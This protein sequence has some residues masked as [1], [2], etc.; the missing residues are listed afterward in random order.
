MR[1]LVLHMLSQP[2]KSDGSPASSVAVVP[3]SQGAPDTVIPAACALDVSWRD[4]VRQVARVPAFVGLGVHTRCAALAAADERARQG[5]IRRARS[6]FRSVLVVLLAKAL[7]EDKGVVSGDAL[8]VHVR[9]TSSPTNG[10]SAA[11]QTPGKTP[12]KPASP[13]YTRGGVASSLVAAGSATLASPGSVGSDA[14]GFGG[15]EATKTGGSAGARKAATVALA[16]ERK[17]TS[18]RLASGSVPPAVAQAY[19]FCVASCGGSSLAAVSVALRPFS[20]IRLGDVLCLRCGIDPTLPSLHIGAGSSVS[21]EAAR[22]FRRTCRKLRIVSSRSKQRSPGELE[23]DAELAAASVR[24]AVALNAPP[25]TIAVSGAAA[26]R[27]LPAS[28]RSAAHTARTSALPH[29]EASRSDVSDVSAHAAAGGSEAAADLAMREATTSVLAAGA[30]RVLAAASAHSLTLAVRDDAPGKKGSVISGASMLGD[31]GADG[32]AASHLP[33]VTASSNAE[34]DRLLAARGDGSSRQRLA[35]WTDSAAFSGSASISDDE[36]SPSMPRRGL[37]GGRRPVGGKASRLGVAEVIGPG[38][39]S[40]SGAGGRSPPGS[41][42]E[43]EA[44]FGNGAGRGGPAGG[45]GTPG[46][47]S[48]MAVRS[49]AAAQ[50]RRAGLSAAAAVSSTE[51]AL[52]EGSGG[53]LTPGAG[54]AAVSP[55]SARDGPDIFFGGAGADM[56]AASASP[57]GKSHLSGALGF[58]P[59][60]PSAAALKARREAAS[61]RRAARGGRPDAAAASSMVDGTEPGAVELAASAAEPTGSSAGD[62]LLPPRSRR[63]WLWP[64]RDRVTLLQVLRFWAP[65]MRRTT[66]LAALG[67]CLR[68]I[69]CL[70]GGTG[71]TPRTSGADPAAGPPPCDSLGAT[72]PSPSHWVRL[73]SAQSLPPGRSDVRRHVAPSTAIGAAA[74]RPGARPGG[75]RGTAGS[76]LQEILFLAGAAAAAAS[77]SVRDAP[78]SAVLAAAGATPDPGASE[79]GLARAGSFPSTPAG[80]P[81]TTFGGVGGVAFPGPRDASARL[82]LTQ[83]ATIAVGGPGGDA[84]GGGAPRVAVPARGSGR[85]LVT[86]DDLRALVE[87]LLQRHPDLRPV[88]TDRL[89]RSRYVTFVVVALS[90]ALRAFASQG[91]SGREITRSNIADALVMCAR[92]SMHGIAPFGP[93]PAMACD[94]F[95]RLAA[96]MPHLAAREPGPGWVTV[97]QLLQASGYPARLAGSGCDGILFLNDDADAAE[98]WKTRPSEPQTAPR[99]A[100]GWPDQALPRLYVARELVHAFARGQSVRRPVAL[101]ARAAVAGRGGPA[102]ASGR[103]GGANTEALLCFEDVCW[104]L[105]AQEDACS[106]T[107]IDFWLRLLSR[108]G[109]DVVSEQDIAAAARAVVFHARD[110]EAAEL[111]NP[112]STGGPDGAGAAARA[113]KEGLLG[114]AAPQAGTPAMPRRGLAVDDEAAGG[115]KKKKRRRRRSSL[116]RLRAPG[117]GRRELEHEEGVA[118]R[119][120]MHQLVDVIRPRRFVSPAPGEPVAAAFDAQDVKKSLCGAAL[121]ELLFKVQ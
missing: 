97:K 111:Y 118:A 15:G 29:S 59:T 63:R 121:F 67:C 8:D 57:G 85:L 89:R 9:G 66:G 11:A 84:G 6:R 35:M 72:D 14:A 87:A 46:V 19:R 58:D 13:G 100:A 106:D 22:L 62:A 18:Q 12:G 80:S 60:S 33:A 49:P 75:L 51:D 40:M 21:A 7:G 43:D 52:T 105:Q 53:R 44:L 45:A 47:R 110:V 101:L 38:Q 74:A 39:T 28:A 82:R 94:Q 32:T 42:D 55:G 36:V 5:C 86:P 90:A 17:G 64:R 16:A 78:Q 34:R 79:A 50:R 65:V 99:L 113:R 73:A 76:S 83:T 30:M 117:L 120:A 41:D 119:A 115:G 56:V 102:S 3:G 95:Y 69:T 81:T 54:S 77:F 26:S 88:A 48:V 20:P 116:L 114:A 1:K 96:S 91:V 98:T 92:G 104:L 109:D 68:S 2:T 4:A 31:D 108:T 24:E 27:T 10:R 93:G 61:A 103:G 23:A 37:R 71:T 112:G 107:S 70:P 25:G